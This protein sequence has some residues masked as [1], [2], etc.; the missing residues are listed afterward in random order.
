MKNKLIR[1]LLP[2][3]LLNGCAAFGVFELSDPQTKLEQAYYLIQ[4]GRNLPAIRLFNDVIEIGRKE[5]NLIVQ[6]QGF[7]G[8]GDVYKI[9]KAYGVQTENVSDFKKSATNF[10][11]AAEFYSKAGYPK[12][13]AMS[14]FGAGWSSVVEKNSV[15]K[16]CEYFKL[17]EISYAKPTENNDDTVGFLDAKKTSLPDLIKSFKEAHKCK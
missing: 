7:N 10:N 4:E 13:A 3:L 9:P 14:Y 8:L 6:A 11:E 5:N 16:G 2:I 1:S 17:S 12:K 15:V